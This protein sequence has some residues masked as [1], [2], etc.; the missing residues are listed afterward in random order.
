MKVRTDFVTNSSSSSFVIA[1]KKFP[2]IDEK[3]IQKYPFLDNFEKWAKAMLLEEGYCYKTK[4]AKEINTKEELL[5]F[6]IEEVYYKICCKYPDFSKDWNTRKK[7]SILMEFLEDSEK[8]LFK[9]EKDLI[10]RRYKL[11]IKRV[12]D[13]EKGLNALLAAYPEG[14]SKDFF[15]VNINEI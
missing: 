11:L 4:A 12:D 15:V 9:K 14:K 5:D 1:Y 10:R 3:T 2:S 6:W 13:D 7:E 8:E